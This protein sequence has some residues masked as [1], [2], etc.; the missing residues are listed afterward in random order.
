MRAA[1]TPNPTVCRGLAAAGADLDLR[2]NTGQTALMLACKAG[3]TAVAEA[4]VA[5]G[6]SVDLQDEAGQTAATQTCPK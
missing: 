2:D 1:R 4:L 6:A 3:H 5:A